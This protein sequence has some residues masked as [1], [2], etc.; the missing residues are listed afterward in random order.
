MR[1]HRFVQT[2]L[3][4]L[5]SIS[6]IATTP[7]GSSEDVL[8]TGGSGEYTEFN[9]KRIPPLTE[10]K[11]ATFDQN[12]K[13][14]YW[15]VEFFSPYC[16]HCHM[17]APTWQ[18]LYEFYYSS[19]PLP[20]TSASGESHNDLNSFTRYYNFKFARVDC[21]AD[22]DT[23]AAQSIQS[24]PSIVLYKDG[25]VVDRKVGGKEMK[26]MVDWVESTLETIRPGSRLP[27]GPKTIPKP[28]DKASAASGADTSRKSLLAGARVVAPTSSNPNPSGKSV[29]LTPETFKKLVTDT[30]DPWFIKFYAPWCHHCKDLAP[31]WQGMARKMQQRL[32]VGEVNC[33][34]E[35]KLCKDLKIPGYPT[36]LFFREGQRIEYEGL[37]GLGDLI[38]YA[39]K[40]VEIGRGIADVTASSFEEMEKKNEVIFL[41]FYD[42]ATTSEDFAALDRMALSLISHAKIVKTNDPELFKRFKISTWPR[43]LVSRDGKATYYPPISPREMRDVHRVLHWMRSVWLPIVPELT[44]SN[45]KEIM[46]GKLVVLGIL[47]RDSPDFEV[48]KK[49]IKNAALEWIDKQSQAFQLER[50]E[51]RDAK[52]LRIEEAEDRN[53]Q[54]AL[55]AAKSIR[56]NM[57]DIE[58]KEVGFAWV[59]GQFWERWVKT[60]FGIRVVEGE[61]VVIND[62]D[63]HRYWENTMTGNPIV[64]SRTSIIETL[65]RVVANPPKIPYKR[66]MTILGHVW[67]VV[68]TQMQEHP[69]VTVFFSLF[70]LVVVAWWSRKYV[71]VAQSG[72]INLSEKGGMD[73]LLGNTAGGK[74]D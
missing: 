37:R 33:E 46:H 34:A 66:T 16:H 27:G 9:S 61:R 7:A 63:N 43:L 39:S 10:L 6:A 69:L 24:Y 12:V 23:C 54:R 30:R 18:T 14:G 74:V 50:Q 20:Q 44:A 64:P 41:Y 32:N 15:L 51:L 22:G 21:V 72:F 47:S 26:E 35:K 68:K 45:A 42:D 65:P 2:L 28:G 49:E 19:D 73:G 55:R 4:S 59:D 29:E 67:W 13:D 60:T 8:T 58:R 25:K 5:L 70:A 38:N 36:V 53:D 11:A 52:Q 71:K 62:Q 1:A 40:A 31:N 3:V 56:I 48:Y 17:F 57:D